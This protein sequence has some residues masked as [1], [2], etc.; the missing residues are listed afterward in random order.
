MS[1]HII[2]VSAHFNDLTKLTSDVS[3]CPAH[4]I[5]VWCDNSKRYLIPGSTSRARWWH[6]RRY[7]GTDR[8]GDPKSRHARINSVDTLLLTIAFASSNLH[9]AKRILNESD[10]HRR[11]DLGQSPIFFSIVTSLH[12]GFF[13]R[14]WGHTLWQE[15][16]ARSGGK[17]GVPR[18][19]I[20]C[21]DNISSSKPT[22]H[23]A[24][25]RYYYGTAAEQR[26]LGHD[27]CRRGITRAHLALCTRTPCCD[28][29]HITARS[30]SS[31][32]AWRPL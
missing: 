27:T 13:C 30:S 16:L 14:I 32:P 26:H 15:L 1:T 5:S 22:R 19:S 23:D 11:Y 7:T 10:A 6:W 21:L 4:I 31:T 20:G 3:G 18:D 25:K 24:Y 29:A 17:P 9:I 8:A 2:F 12:I 28:P